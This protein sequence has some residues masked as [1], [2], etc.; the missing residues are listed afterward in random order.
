MNFKI[1]HDSRDKEQLLNFSFP[2]SE[3]I[4]IVQLFVLLVQ[5]CAAALP[6]AHMRFSPK[7]DDYIYA[8]KLL[9][10]WR[11][12]NAG[13]S[14]LFTIVPLYFLQSQI[15][16]LVF[17][18]SKSFLALESIRIKYERAGVHWQELALEE[19]WRCN[20]PMRKS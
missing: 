20:Q 17:I 5:K 13:L 2:C 18:H 7:S 15:N 19:G 16:I 8:V 11:N 6:H 1:N 12:K 9:H 10:Y 4:S 3:L 14:I